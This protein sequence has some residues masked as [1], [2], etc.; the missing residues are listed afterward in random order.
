MVYTWSAPTHDTLR[1]PPPLQPQ[2]QLGLPAFCP[3]P[4]RRREGQQ[5][6]FLTR[7]PESLV[8]VPEVAPVPTIA[9]LSGNEGLFAYAFGGKCARNIGRVH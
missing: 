2:L 6:K 1:A 4:E 9:G 3:S 5:T 8:R 7:D